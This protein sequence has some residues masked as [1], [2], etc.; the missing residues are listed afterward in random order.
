MPKAI[1]AP[2]GP[3]GDQVA[4]GVRQIL[5]VVGGFLVTKG[6]IDESTLQMIVGVAAV[7]VPLLWGQLKVRRRAS[8]VSTLA[9]YVDNSVATKR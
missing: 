9:D 6:T 4:A 3:A 2:N 5:L 7:A 1:Q 8:E